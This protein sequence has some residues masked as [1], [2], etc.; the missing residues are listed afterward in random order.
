MS[1]LRSHSLDTFQH[2]KQVHESMLN[3]QLDSNSVTAKQCAD[4]QSLAHDLVVPHLRLSQ[5]LILF[6]MHFSAQCLDFKLAKHF[7]FVIAMAD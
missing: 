4:A 3:E 7:M 5:L 2:D 6:G 1:P